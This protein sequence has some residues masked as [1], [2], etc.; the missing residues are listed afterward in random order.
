[1]KAREC[2]LNRTLE[3][4]QMVSYAVAL[5]TT[6]QMPSASS[7]STPNGRLATESDFPAAGR[8]PGWSVRK[9]LPVLWA[10]NSPPFRHPSNHCWLG[11]GNPERQ[12]TTASGTTPGQDQP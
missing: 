12:P 6:R 10:T 9:S 5:P 8:I 1:M 7:T 4:M 11:F 3:P 2:V